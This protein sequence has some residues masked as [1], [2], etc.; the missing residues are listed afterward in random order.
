MTQSASKPNP[1]RK[2]RSYE[3]FTALGFLL[4]GLFVLN[5]FRCDGYISMGTGGFSNVTT[6]SGGMAIFV[7]AITIGFGLILT[8][9]CGWAWYQ[10]V[11]RS[12]KR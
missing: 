3:W 7:I 12:K 2:P 5:K 9:W 11:R 1:P 10:N 8:L 6:Y 4:G